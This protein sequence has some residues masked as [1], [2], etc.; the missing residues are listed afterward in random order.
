MIRTMTLLCLFS[1]VASTACAVDPGETS[2]PDV[3]LDGSELQDYGT[4]YGGWT[5]SV[6]GS[7]YACQGSVSHYLQRSSG[8]STRSGGSCFITPTSTSCSSDS[9]CVSAALS[10]Y[11]ASAYGYCV[12]GSCY[13]RPGSDAEFCVKGQN[14]SSGSYLSNSFV[15]CGGGFV[16]GCMSKSSTLP[17][18]C[19][20]QN[21]SDA[22]RF[23]AP[24][25]YEPNG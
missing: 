24:V 11:G 12:G 2:A 23:V 15:Y 4:S 13:L 20:V 1:T 16:L 18:A 9:T 22:M 10:T 6:G 25:M 14:R 5:Q 21:P 8:D 17:F 3:E 19:A 7:V